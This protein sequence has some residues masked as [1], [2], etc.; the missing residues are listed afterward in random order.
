MNK[1]DLKLFKKIRNEPNWMNIYFKKNKDIKCW[2]D[3]C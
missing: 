2:I 1:V 3:A